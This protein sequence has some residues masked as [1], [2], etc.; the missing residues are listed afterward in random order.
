MVLSFAL[1][2]AGFAAA[3]GG[4]QPDAQA[5]GTTA[6]ASAAPP[7]PPPTAIAPV[8]TATETAA[9]PTTKPEPPAPP[10]VAKV[11]KEATTKEQQI[12]YMK[13]N[14][15]APMAKVFQASDTKRYADFGCMTC[16]GPKFL[17]PKAFL[18]KLTMKNGK[19]VAKPETVKFMAEK[20][21]PAMASAMGEAPWDPK[22]KQGFGCGS[23]HVIDVK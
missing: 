12:A 11:W 17:E 7:A 1:V 15:V 8:P 10:P 14:V 2:S 4:G 6:S 22:T 23:C 16:H 21:V 13:A 5:P 18:P 20:V 3:C 19:F 9:A